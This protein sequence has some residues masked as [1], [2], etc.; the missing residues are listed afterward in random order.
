MKIL[1]ASHT[2]IV[3]LNREK[4]RK[5]AQL[6]PSI[7]VTVVV[8]KRWRPGGVQ[9]KI[10][11]TQPVDEGNFRVVPLSNLS[12]NNQGLLT[13][14]LDLVQLL[15]TFK[16]HILQTEQGAKAFSHAE[17]ITLNKQLNLN[18]KNVFF[19]WWNL[20]YEVKF[21]ISVLEGFNLKH[22]H[23]I[24]SGNQDG[25]DVLRDHGY[26]GPIKVMPQLGVDEQL[27]SPQEQPELRIS[28]GI[29][30]DEFVVGFVGR[31]VEE[32]GLLTL[33]NALKKITDYP[34][35][36]LLLGRG[37]LKQDLLNKASEV[38]LRDR[39]ICVE[40]VPHDQ[41]YRY[42]NLMDVLVLPSETT[43]KF[44]TLT[45]A[46]WKEQFG[47]VLIEAMSCKVPV[48]GSDSGE[49]PHVIDEAGLVFPEGNV[50]GLRN[51]LRQ[52][53]EN[54]EFR[55]NL[56]QKGYERAMLHYTNTALAKEQYSFYEQLL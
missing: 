41:V 35:K 56:A 53:M 21:P 13:F 40:S 31:F 43:Y 22:S 50:D 17:L 18:A 32:K 47:H 36:W 33:F 52:V 9:N 51:G 20:P 55:Q 39:L 45:A 23:G 25:A 6:D 38:G 4:L 44:K 3:D 8:P 27:F 19:T 28:L 2:Y 7:E 10:I 48:I 11:E 26:D 12:E 49:I 54:Q 30:P 15:K 14:G 37:D 42:I 5:L 16:P 29:E 34:W 46:G 1:I 24:I